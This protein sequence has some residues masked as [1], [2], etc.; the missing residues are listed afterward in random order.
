MYIKWAGQWNGMF[1]CFRSCSLL[2]TQIV[3][4]TIFFLFFFFLNITQASQQNEYSKVLS[5]SVAGTSWN[6]LFPSLKKTSRN[7]ENKN[8]IN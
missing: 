6:C 2:I 5:L 3:V 1:G 4:N 7:E 8:Q